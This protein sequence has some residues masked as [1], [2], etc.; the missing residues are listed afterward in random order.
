MPGGPG[1]TNQTQ[2][3][4]NPGYQGRG[5]FSPVRTHTEENLFRSYFVRMNSF[6]TITPALR[7]GSR[8]KPHALRLKR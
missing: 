6:P 7:T 3:P 2:K 5:P 1:K 8:R 4:W